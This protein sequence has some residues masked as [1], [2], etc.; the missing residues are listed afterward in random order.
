[1]LFNELSEDWIFAKYNSIS[2]RY[3]TC[4]KLFKLIQKINES[5]TLKGL[6]VKGKD[7]WYEWEGQISFK[8]KYDA[9]V[10]ELQAFILKRVQKWENEQLWFLK[11][12]LGKE[13][14][15]RRSAE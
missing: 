4:A 2:R 7:E 6:L 5:S 12:D 9:N 10:V 8:I 13:S 3:S 15:W 1:M 11:E 14:D